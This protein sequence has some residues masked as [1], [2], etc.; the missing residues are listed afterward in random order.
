MLVVSLEV[1]MQKIKQKK[2]KQQKLSI[3]LSRKLASEVLVNDSTVNILLLFI[4]DKGQNV[5]CPKVKGQ[6]SY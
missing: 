6:K 1:K 5:K 3:H 4:L 2:W